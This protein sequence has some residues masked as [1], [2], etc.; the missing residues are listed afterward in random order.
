MIHAVFDSPDD[1]EWRKLLDYL[2]AHRD[3]LKG[4]IVVVHGDNGLTA[5]Q[6]SGLA[7]VI[8]GMR[9]GFRSAVM[10]ES[11]VTRGVLTA[12]NWLTKK[13]DDSG[14]FALSDFDG[15]AAF[16]GMND[17][18]RRSA[19]VLAD[20]LGAFAKQGRVASR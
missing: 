19:R 7:E 15:A 20:K 14:A 1:N 11:R 18:E 10:T 16:L 5:K 13:Q 9:P 3:T 6:R 17:A 12:L 4:T 8:K 2:T